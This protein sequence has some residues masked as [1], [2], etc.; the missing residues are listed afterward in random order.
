ML[1]LF[2]TTIGFAC[3]ACHSQYF[4][5]PDDQGN[6]PLRIKDAVGIVF[7]PPYWNLCE[8]QNMFFDLKFAIEQVC[9]FPAW[10]LLHS[11]GI[12]TR[13]D[14]IWNPC[15]GCSSPIDSWRSVRDWLF[16]KEAIKIFI[17]WFLILAP[18]NIAL[19]MIGRY[20][21]KLVGLMKPIEKA[22]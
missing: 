20:T 2:I 8:R 5:Y 12:V 22:E 3:V 6:I 11:L 19:I 10:Y 18:T 13:Y 17:S 4:N 21:R 16:W 1:A 14:E 15:I 9:S 7:V